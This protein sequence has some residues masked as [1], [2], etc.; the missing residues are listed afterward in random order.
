MF[1]LVYA[2]VHVVNY[3]K[4]SIM[5]CPFCKNEII[6]GATVCGHCGAQK[7]ETV[8]CLG[9]LV[10]LIIPLIVGVFFWLVTQNSA[11]SV[12]AGIICFFVWLKILKKI[13][14][15]RRNVWER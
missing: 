13:I 11:I 9:T 14:L 15:P 12:I 5:T 2:K 10:C 7:K 1:F 3:E 4:G 8:G 6:D